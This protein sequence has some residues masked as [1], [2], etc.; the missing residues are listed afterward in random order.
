M[1]NVLEGYNRTVNYVNK[2]PW[3]AKCKT[4]AEMYGSGQN[5]CEK[6]WGDS[7]RYVK[8]DKNVNNCMKMW[9]TPGFENPN[10]NVVEFSS[11]PSPNVLSSI[12]LLAVVYAVIALN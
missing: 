10:A 6:M 7:Y 1:E 3:G 11:S 9:F 4:Y 2:C 12:L 5:L 8:K